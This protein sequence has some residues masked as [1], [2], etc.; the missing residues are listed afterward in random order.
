LNS[1][2]FDCLLVEE[3]LHRFDRDLTQ[4]HVAELE[5]VVCADIGF[6]SMHSAG[7]QQ[8]LYKAHDKVFDIL[9]AAHAQ[10]D[11]LKGGK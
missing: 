3:C 5:E 4:L 8:H 10:Y 9:R 11:K 6:V 1:L 2:A 7:R